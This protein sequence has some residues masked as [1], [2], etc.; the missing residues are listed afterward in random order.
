MVVENASN[1]LINLA[2]EPFP[3]PM[4]ISE[5]EARRTYQSEAEFFEALEPPSDGNTFATSVTLNYEGQS[6]IYHIR[7]WVDVGYQTFQAVNA[8]IDV[9]K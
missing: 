8:I 1:P 4:T 5:V 6:G 7:I 2:Y 9:G 3:E